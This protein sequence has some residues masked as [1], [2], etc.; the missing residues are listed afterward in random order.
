MKYA[1]SLVFEKKENREKRRNIGI[2]FGCF[3]AFIELLQLYQSLVGIE[4]DDMHF[5]RNLEKLNPPLKPC[6]TNQVQKV[7]KKISS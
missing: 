1:Q 2:S 6:V 3:L 4:I 5:D 7:E